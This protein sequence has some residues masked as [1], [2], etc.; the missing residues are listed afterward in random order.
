[1]KKE[2]RWTPQHSKSSPLYTRMRSHDSG[3]ATIPNVGTNPAAGVQR[4]HTLLVGSQAIGTW[5]AHTRDKQRHHESQE[6]QR[7]Q[8]LKV[9]VLEH[10]C[11][12]WSRRGQAQALPLCRG[13]RTC[14]IGNRPKDHK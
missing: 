14:G 10:V 8:V 6:F 11:H 7:P 4:S 9:R 5:S 12:I 2:T 13:R 3:E 1:M